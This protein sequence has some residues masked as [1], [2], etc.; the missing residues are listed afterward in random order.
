M[1]PIKTRTLRV[2]IFIHTSPSKVFKAI[3]EPQLLTRWFMDRAT[4]P[5][6][7][8]GNYSFAW[9]GGPTHVGKV[10]EFI[11]GRR[12]TL[13]WTWPGQEH[14]GATKLMLSVQSKKNGSVVWFTH[15]GFRTGGEWVDLYEGALRGWTYFMMNLK[16]VL[17]NGHDLR[18]PDDW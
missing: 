9:E 13:A 14:L 2:P 15:S 17:E 18:S 7:K 16:S 10:L 6:R 5:P 11:R 12:I 8:G 4:L 1:G 3:S